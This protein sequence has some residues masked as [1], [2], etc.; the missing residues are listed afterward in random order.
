MRRRRAPT[1]TWPVTTDTEWTEV[2]ACLPGDGTVLVWPGGEPAPTSGR[3][4][5]DTWLLRDGRRVPLGMGDTWQPLPAL[6]GR[7]A[8]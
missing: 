7:V 2:L 1:S 5:G 4:A 3:L 6:E 8:A